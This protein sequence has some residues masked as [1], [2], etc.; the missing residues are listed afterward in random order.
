M[1]GTLSDGALWRIR[2]PRQWNRTLILYSHG[3]L[4]DVRPPALAPVG[5]ESWLL[6]H[7]YALAASSYAHGGWA[8]ADAVPDQLETAAVF[9]VR[10]AIPQ[11]IIAWGESM[12]GLVTVALAERAD[13]PLDGALSACGSVAGTLDMMNQ[14]LDGAFA[15]TTLVAPHAGIRMVDVA[16]DRANGARVSAALREA[17][18]TPRGRARVALATAL[19][20]L[21]VWTQPNSPEPASGDYAGQL[22]QVAE[23]FVAGVFLPRA[24]QERV[25][26]G[27]FSWNTDTEYRVQ[28][29]RTGRRAWVEHYYREAG[30]DLEQ[31]LRALNAAP[32]VR[33]VPP[34]VDYM[35]AN[36]VPAG[37][38]RVPLMSYHTLGDGL[39][40][41]DLQ[42]AYSQ[43]VDRNNAGANFRAAWVRGA[44]H[45]TFTIGEHVAALRTLE[46]RLSAGSW[47]TQPEKLNSVVAREKLG[48]GRF[49]RALNGTPRE[50]RD[51]H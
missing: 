31:D 37:R 18:G 12:G 25:A 42:R 22:A 36:Y 49:V 35:R 39:T 8:V 46:R 47:E 34:A 33:A 19:A 45:C 21:P 14:A 41:P 1:S 6:E 30:A 3:Y 2:V 11:R 29:A 17:L 32:R 16:D 13:S 23:S 27:V 4:P 15:F 44:G 10:V 38:P 9:K 43:E 50:S 51:S 7:G 24:E 40:S 48:A 26:G 5:L 28:L 20:G